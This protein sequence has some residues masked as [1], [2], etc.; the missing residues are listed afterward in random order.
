VK[1][2]EAAAKA[3]S[4]G[5]LSPIPR[6]LST[7]GFA[8]PPF[9][10]SSEP[11]IQAP[12]KGVPLV[13]TKATASPR[14]S[15][16]QTTGEKSPS[17]GKAQGAKRQ[18]AR[19][20]SAGQTAPPAQESSGTSGPPTADHPMVTRSRK[21]ASGAGSL[22]GV[23]GSGQSGTGVDQEGPPPPNLSRNLFP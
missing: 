12:A 10:K 6:P 8:S 16:G 1:L 11:T 20:Q 17:Q 13:V 4:E 3:H 5:K 15:A 9:Q 22:R 2:A 19:Q 7:P 23:T 18:A 21:K 14:A